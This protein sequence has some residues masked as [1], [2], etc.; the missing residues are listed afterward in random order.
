MSMEKTNVSLDETRSGVIAKGFVNARGC[1]IEKAE[2][3][4]IVDVEGREFIDFGGGIAVMNND[5]R[6][7][8]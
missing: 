4:T 1:Y 5:R 6:P 2:G 7:I 3:A 8:W